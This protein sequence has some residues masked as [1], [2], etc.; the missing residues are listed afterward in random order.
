MASMTGAI[1]FLKN[2]G[3]I[4]PLTCAGTVHQRGGAS[5]PAGRRFFGIIP[6]RSRSLLH[7]RP[8]SSQLARSNTGNRMKALTAKDAKYGFGQPIHLVRAE[9]IAVAGRGA[10]SIMS[11]PFIDHPILNSPYE[12]PMRYWELDETGQPT[13]RSLRTDVVP[14][15]IT[16]IPKPKKRKAT[17][18]SGFVFDEGKGLSTK[19]QQYDPTSIINEVRTPRFAQGF[20]RCPAF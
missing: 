15:F 17:A 2:N 5:P 1:R 9:P 14:K 3:R 16:P 10:A 4:F 11:N 20:W 8:Y 7:I 6:R 12:Y 19:E 18:Q 13:R